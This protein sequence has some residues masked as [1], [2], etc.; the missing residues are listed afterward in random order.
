MLLKDSFLVLERLGFVFFLPFEDPNGMLPARPLPIAK[1]PRKIKIGS[2]A[3]SP[4][5]PHLKT[6]GQATLLNVA[7]LRSVWTLSLL[8]AE[9]SYLTFTKAVGPPISQPSHHSEYTVL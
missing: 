4:F 7:V 5:E 2:G 1:R 9:T 6:L 3:W 8:K